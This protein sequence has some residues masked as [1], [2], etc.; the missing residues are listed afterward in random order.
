MS[1][2]TEKSKKHAG[3]S[4]PLALYDRVRELAE[5]ESRTMANMLMI[6]VVEALSKRETS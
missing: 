5:R 3:V 1:K 2:R 6:L 4:L